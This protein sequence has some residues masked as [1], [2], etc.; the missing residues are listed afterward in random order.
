M[1]KKKDLTTIYTNAPDTNFWTLWI[2]AWHQSTFWELPLSERVGV[3]Y[4]YFLY[5]KGAVTSASF[6]LAEELIFYLGGICLGRY[7]WVV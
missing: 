2:I 5:F 1:E 7:E 3:L 4:H 6:S